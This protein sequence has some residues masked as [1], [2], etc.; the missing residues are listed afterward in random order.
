MS[1][2]KALPARGEGLAALGRPLQGS[3]RAHEASALA[4]GVSR[5]RLDCE[6]NSW[7]GQRGCIL[8]LPRSPC[9][10]AFVW[11][12]SCSDLPLP[13]LPAWA[14]QSQRFCASGSLPARLIK[15]SPG[16]AR[17]DLAFP[18]DVS[19]AGRLAGPGLEGGS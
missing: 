7:A 1:A 4:V 17:E 8:L 16:A 11:V 5:P 15:R 6:N 14:S 2:L 3:S 19:R 10:L 18:S 12:S 13:V 9:L